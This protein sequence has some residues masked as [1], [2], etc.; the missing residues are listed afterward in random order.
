M[1]IYNTF[2]ESCL[3]ESNSQNSMV[4]LNKDSNDLL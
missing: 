3:S 2:I 1:V 4:A